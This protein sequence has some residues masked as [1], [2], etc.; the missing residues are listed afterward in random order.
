MVSVPYVLALCFFINLWWT[1]FIAVLCPSSLNLY[2]ETNFWKGSSLGGFGGCLCLVLLL[3][4]FG[5][6]GSSSG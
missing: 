4:L 1:F 2:N 6:V 5:L 3:E